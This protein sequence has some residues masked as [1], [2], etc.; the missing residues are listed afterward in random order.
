MT[1]ARGLIEIN[2]PVGTSSG[3]LADPSNTITVISPSGW[4][5]VSGS[6]NNDF[7]FTPS[8]GGDAIVNGDD[9]LIFTFTIT[10]NSV[11]G[12]AFVT[13]T[14]N[15]DDGDDVELPVF[16]VP[17][18]FYLKPFLA[19]PTEVSLG[20]TSTL[21]WSGSP[22]YC[23]SITLPDMLQDG[24]IDSSNNDATKT[25]DNGN[26]VVG[27]KTIALPQ[28]TTF[29]LSVAPTKDEPPFINE[30]ITV[31]VDMPKVNRFKVNNTAVTG[32]V[33]P[34][35]CNL[36]T[37]IKF[38]WNVSYADYVIL[39]LNEVEI[40]SYPT[41]SSDENIDG[42]I[43]FQI[44]SPGIYSIQAYASYGDIE[45]MSD[46]SSGIQINLNPPEVLSLAAN[47]TT[48]YAN[49]TTVALVWTTKNA[50]SVQLFS[51]LLNSDGTP[52]A[53]REL[54]SNSLNAVVFNGY[55]IY[56]NQS[57]RYTLQAICNENN[58]NEVSV[59]VMMRSCPFDIATKTFYPS[60]PDWTR[61]LC[62]PPEEITGVALGIVN[63]S[64]KFNDGNGNNLKKLN[65]KAGY[66]M[67]TD[68][69]SLTIEPSME[70]ENNNKGVLSS[71]STMSII[72][73]SICSNYDLLGFQAE[74]WTAQ[75]G[76][77]Y[78]PPSPHT[79]PLSPIGSIAT[80]LSGFQFKNDDHDGKVSSMN[81]SVGQPSKI[82]YDINSDL[83]PNAEVN[84][85]VSC[86]G[87]QDYECSMSLSL[88]TSIL[89]PVQGNGIDFKFIS[90][91]TETVGFDY[92]IQSAYTVMTNWTTTGN[93]K[94]NTIKQLLA[95]GVTA[96]IT[97]SGKDVS[98]E[99]GAA[100]WKDNTN[101]EWKATYDAI[102]IVAYADHR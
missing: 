92:P 102:V 94:D 73:I 59:D 7:I 72:A 17:A 99:W 71:D 55:L 85:D 93:Q 25:D 39:L 47:N 42:S 49:Y 22:N 21:S 45:D 61:V 76:T 68:R 91:G 2:I 86:K 90:Y 26:T 75:E 50:T 82:A 18:Q 66:S 56:P 4:G 28:T 70:L 34:I 83:Y 54:V 67:S 35:N 8:D 74:I 16:K 79:I 15:D 6:S 65:I 78:Y 14:E 46:P 84:C 23:Y 38:D 57:T 97:S 60:D 89:E 81:A 13:F 88:L 43:E 11:V 87:Q 53:D 32:I 77:S 98:L 52:A 62:N 51:Q 3:S 69:T 9:P 24:Q 44:T 27:I 1:Y 37:E 96:T 31:T 64:Y 33:E 5:F 80:F 12:T 100:Y 101:D 48:I 20:G 58:S 10:V 41:S 95:G 30:S 40:C 19:D 29:V 36:D 63:F